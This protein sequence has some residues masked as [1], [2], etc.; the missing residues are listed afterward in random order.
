MICSHT[1]PTGVS[2]ISTTQARQCVSPSRRIRIHA[3]HR[4][5]N[6]RVI[7]PDRPTTIERQTAVR[8]ARSRRRH[9]LGE[10][11]ARGPSSSWRIYR[12]GSVRATP[13][14]PR[15]GV[16]DR[17]ITGYH[18]VEL[19]RCRDRCFQRSHRQYASNHA[20]RIRRDPH[21]CD[22]RQRSGAGLRRPLRLQR[23]S[24]PLVT[25]PRTL[26]ARPRIRPGKAIPVSLSSLR[27]KVVV[28]AFYPLDRS[29]GCTAELSKFRDEY[30]TLFGSG[31]V[32]L[33]TSVDSLGSHASWAKESHFPFAMIADTKGELATKVWIAGRGPTD[34]QAHGVRD[35][36]GRQDRVRRHAVQRARA[37]RLRQ[38]RRG[39]QDGE[40]QL[41][42]HRVEGCASDV[43][44]ALVAS[45]FID[46]AGGP[47]RAGAGSRGASGRDADADRVHHRRSDA[48]RLLRAVFFAAQGRARTPV[49]RRRGV[50]Q[51]ISGSRDHRDGA[52]SLSDDVGPI[53]SSH[54]IVT[55]YGRSRRASPLVGGGGAG[56]V[57]IPLSR[58]D[59]DRLAGAKD[60]RSR[61][62]SRFHERI[63][64]RF[65]RW[66]A[67]NKVCS[68]TRATGASR[69]ARTTPTRCRRG[70]S[71][72]TRARSR[73]TL[74]WEVVD[75][76]ASRAIVSRA[77][78]G[79]DGELR[80]Q[81]RLSVSLS[82][83]PRA[84]SALV[85]R[86]SSDGFADRAVRARWTRRDGIRS[87]PTDGYSRRLV[88]DD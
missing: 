47:L 68:G 48:G 17:M 64:E 27:G 41:M 58:N 22:A 18:S 69:R 88:L 78:L 66:A 9:S 14:P 13:R 57:T 33:P 8:Q 2:S 81:F 50:H 39:D 1:L 21:R 63:A 32:V 76:A 83:R 45:L 46:D 86:I 54:G 44:A 82:G 40:R 87:R 23:R 4:A 60:P 12:C 10:R 3:A 20:P 49:S 73:Q 85:L 55:N 75:A 15:V 37:G 84:G 80:K 51:R 70:F 29:T 74:R 5:R 30:A 36:E 72:S 71:I 43:H 7:Q 42:Q 35:R 26:Q 79:A 6:R 61:A 77:R 59:A 56:R 31:V 25:P 52:G 34:V 38:T 11:A 28:L 62:L 19:L 65:C 24:R 67:Q 16:P 53:S